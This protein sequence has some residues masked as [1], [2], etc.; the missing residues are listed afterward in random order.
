[1]KLK[2]NRNTKRF[3]I[4]NPY[5]TKY[6]NMRISSV[7]NW[8]VMWTHLFIIAMMIPTSWIIPTWSIKDKEYCNFLFGDSLTADEVSNPGQICVLTFS[9][10]LCFAIAP[11]PSQPDCPA[12]WGE[13]GRPLLC[14]PVQAVGGPD[15]LPKP[16]KTTKSLFSRDLVVLPVS[17]HF[18][19]RKVSR[20]SQTTKSLENNVFKGFGCFSC[21]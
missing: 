11:S 3:Q 21:F 4:R 13:A 5:S 1:M 2:L 9:P 7:F 16:K 12:V 15:S 20:N 6:T 8:I 10:G 18:F 14:K 19:V 17:R